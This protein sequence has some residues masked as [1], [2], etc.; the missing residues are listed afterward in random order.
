MIQRTK[1]LGQQERR[2]KTRARGYRK[3]KV[4]RYGGHGGDGNRG[5]RHRPLRGT[6]DAIVERVFVGV[7]AAV[8][9]GEEEGVDTAAL[10][11]FG[12]FDPVGEF[13]LCGGFVFGVLPLTGGEVAYCAHVECVDEDLLL[14]QRIAGSC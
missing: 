4:L 2:L 12:Q 5:V 1:P 7:V 9:V 6:P 10:E 14:W 11:Q 8:C 13:T 3:R